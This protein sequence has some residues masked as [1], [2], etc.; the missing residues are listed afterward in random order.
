MS[1]P[2]PPTCHI[3]HTRPADYEAIPQYFGALPC[4]IHHELLC[5]WDVHCRGGVERYIASS[6]AIR[7]HDPTCAWKQMID[8]NR[9]LAVP[10]NGSPATVKMV[11]RFVA[12]GGGKFLVC[13]HL[14]DT[15]SGKSPPRRGCPGSYSGARHQCF[16]SYM[17]YHS[18]SDTY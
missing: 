3:R 17:F 15:I 13:R 4:I 2:Q 14:L 7:P 16:F 18:T 12:T 5:R 10:T 8:S 1:K 9:G 6:R 11:P